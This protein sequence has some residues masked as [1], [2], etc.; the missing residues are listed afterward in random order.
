VAAIRR[1]CKKLRETYEVNLVIANA[2]NTAGGV[3]VD[4]DSL[5]S[6]QQAGVDVITLGDHVWSKREIIS[7]FNKNEPE[8]C[9]C[10]R[11]ANYP[12]GTPGAG[13][14]VIE[15]APDIK[16]AVLN[17]LGRTFS[18]YFLDCPFRKVDELLGSLSP[19]VKIKILDFH[20]EAT[21]EKA[22]MARYLDGR[23]SIVF[24]THTHVPT[25]DEQIFEGGT[26]FISDLGMCGVYDGV[27]GMDAQTAINRFVSGMPHS[28]KAASGHTRISGIVVDVDIESGKA[29]EIERLNIEVRI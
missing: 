19:D 14:L 21:S 25:A 23:S 24:G 7:I 9:R 4:A 15:H 5:K 18:P 29:F 2:E 3:G 1:Q 17:L 10:I 20:C 27:I 6:L 12:P 26:A 22:A 28:Y 8:E 13:L 16:V 11:P